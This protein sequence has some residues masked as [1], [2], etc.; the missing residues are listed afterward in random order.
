MKE[1]F[2]GSLRDSKLLIS[3]GLLMS[4]ITEPSAGYSPEVHGGPKYVERYGLCSYKGKIRRLECYEGIPFL[5]CWCNFKNSTVLETAFQT[6]YLCQYS[7]KSKI[8][9]GKWRKNKMTKKPYYD[10][11]WEDVKQFF[12]FLF[13]FAQK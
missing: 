6:I 8:D 10:Y 13:F 11:Q 4:A 7:F 2:A 12:F 3:R 1:P 5:T 9:I